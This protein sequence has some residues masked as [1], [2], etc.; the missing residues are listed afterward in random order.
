MK[1]MKRVAWRESKKFKLESLPPRKKLG[2]NIRV[3][4]G[5]LEGGGG[6]GGGGRE[7][8]KDFVF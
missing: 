5:K 7:N 6:V 8:F 1:N 4:P 2:K 3:L